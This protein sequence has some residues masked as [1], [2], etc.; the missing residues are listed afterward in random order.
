VYAQFP[1]PLS[2]L[3]ELTLPFFTVQSRQVSLTGV[4]DLTRTPQ[5]KCLRL[6]GLQ[7][8][9]GL[10]PAEGI[11]PLFTP[12]QTPHPLETIQIVVTANSTSKK[13]LEYKCWNVLDEILSQPVFA[14]LNR[15][16]ITVHTT[17]V[18]PDSIPVDSK[19][20]R[21]EFPA[22]KASQSVFVNVIDSL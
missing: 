18:S 7:W 19:R 3:R 10:C 22:L 20:L 13:A 1:N 21:D 15:V 6:Y 4:I 11:Q 8:T 16:E 2:I 17:R 5:L 14:S 9:G 12:V